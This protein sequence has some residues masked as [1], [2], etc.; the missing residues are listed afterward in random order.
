M[1]SATFF[2]LLL[3]Q[4]VL[5]PSNEEMSLFE[6]RKDSSSTTNLSIPFLLSFIWTPSSFASCT[7][8]TK[9]PPISISR[10]FSCLPF[11]IKNVV[12]DGFATNPFYAINLKTLSASSSS[13]F[14]TICISLSFKARQVYTFHD[15]NIQPTWQFVSLRQYFCS[16]ECYAT[17]YLGK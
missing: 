11:K 10:S 5:E 1:L 13:F 3:I 16:M 8:F 2:N 6:W 12:L 7:C 4:L 15:W 14:L 17:Y 9:L